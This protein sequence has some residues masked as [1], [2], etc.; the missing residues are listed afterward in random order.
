MEERGTIILPSWET[1]PATRLHLDVELLS[2]CKSLSVTM[3]PITYL[4]HGLSMK[5]ISLQFK[6]KNLVWKLR[7]SG[8]HSS[9][10]TV[11]L[12]KCPSNKSWYLKV[13]NSYFIVL[14]YIFLLCHSQTFLFPL[15]G[16]GFVVTT[17]FR[18]SFSLQEDKMEPLATQVCDVPFDCK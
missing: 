5:S 10:L 8:F 13:T 2:N 14:V 7:V 6:D 4:P 18:T 11:A 15:S 1:P 16:P 9:L 17:W 3:Q 12:E